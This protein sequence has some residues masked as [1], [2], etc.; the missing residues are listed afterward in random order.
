VLEDGRHALTGPVLLVG[1]E[2]ELRRYAD[3]RLRRA[4]APAEQVWWRDVLDALGG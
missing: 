4:A 1:R 3:E 2:A